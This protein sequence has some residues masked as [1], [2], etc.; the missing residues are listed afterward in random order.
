MTDQS[1]PDRRLVSNR[2][3]SL[4]LDAAL[5]CRETL[6]EDAAKRILLNHQIP[7]TISARVLFHSEARRLP[8][9]ARSSELP[10]VYLK[11]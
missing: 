8:E 6:G 2:Q 11:S 10:F 7:S 5:K 1:L 9:F 3:V 4:I